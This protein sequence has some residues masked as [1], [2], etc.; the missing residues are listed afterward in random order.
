MRVLVSRQ[1]HARSERGAT[2]ITAGILAAVLVGMAAFVVDFGMAYVSKRQLQTAA[3]AAALAAASTFADKAGTCTT[4]T[5][6]SPYK[7]AATTTAQSYVT[8]NRPGASMDSITFG[9]SSGGT[10]TVDVTAS[11]KTNLAFGGVFIDSSGIAAA[12]TAQ[13]TLGVAAEGTG[14]R[15]YALCSLDAEAS[16]LGTGTVYEIQQPGNAHTGSQCPSSEKGGNWWFVNCPE[17]KAKGGGPDITEENLQ[18]GCDDP[19]SIVPN[20]NPSTPA[21]LS[22]SLTLNCND[23]NDVSS[24]CLSGGEGNSDLKNAKVYD[25]WGKLLG[26]TILLPVFCGDPTCSPSSVSGSGTNTTY[27]IYKVAAVVLCGYHIY[28]KASGSSATG[29]CSGN[30]F[31]SSYVSSVSK[32]EVRLYLKFVQIMTSGS[33]KGNGCSLSTACDGGLRQVLLTK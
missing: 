16:R 7:S 31:S 22:S 32:K 12:R 15:P 3:D 29:A 24:S 8:Q 18:K 30:T 2:A 11:A 10:L 4:L 6:S 27:P 21:T 9:C 13:A 28:D 5:A 33:T 23:S 20:Q 19:I 1:R 25:E 26:Q 14:V 17:D